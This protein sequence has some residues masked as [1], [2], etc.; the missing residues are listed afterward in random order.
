[1]ADIDRVGKQRVAQDV[2]V[3][4]LLFDGRFDYTFGSGWLVGGGLTIGF[5]SAKGTE[6]EGDE[7][8]EGSVVSLY[9]P[10]GYTF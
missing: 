9:F 3:A 7:S 1:M 10:I 4:G 5:G 2:L 8:A 6:T